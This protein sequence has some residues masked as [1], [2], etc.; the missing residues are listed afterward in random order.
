[1]VPIRFHTLL[2]GLIMLLL[3]C[4]PHNPGAKAASVAGGDGRLLNRESA[5]LVNQDFL[6]KKEVSTSTGSRKL[7]GWRMVEEQA[8]DREAMKS[9][10]EKKSTVAASEQISGATPS[11]AKYENEKEGEPYV[12]R[13]LSVVI[14]AR[15]KH[16]VAKKPFQTFKAAMEHKE[17]CNFSFKAKTSPNSLVGM[18]HGK[19]RGKVSLPNP[20]PSCITDDQGSKKGSSSTAPSKA[21]KVPDG[22]SEEEKESERF[23]K[24]AL[25]TLNMLSMDYNHKPRRKP[26]I[27]NDHPLSKAHVFKP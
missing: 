18:E 6:L 7:K 20:E 19:E 14:D 27:N 17:K 22:H 24:E 10:E 8:D 15:S 12:D 9:E 4:L 21:E 5:L 23:M 1:M 2:L 16:G 3:L 11:V 13:K 25:D 26:P